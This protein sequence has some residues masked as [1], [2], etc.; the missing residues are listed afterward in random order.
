[1]LMRKGYE[2]ELAHDALRR[3][4]GAAPATDAAAPDGAATLPADCAGPVPVL[5]SAHSDRSGRR[6]PV[7]LQQICTF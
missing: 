7:K 3:H 1:M 5:R 4:A 2:L 6:G